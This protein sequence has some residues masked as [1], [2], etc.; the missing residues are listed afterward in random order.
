EVTGRIGFSGLVSTGDTTT[1]FVG[2][3]VEPEADTELS[4]MSYTVGGKDLV[5]RD[6][7]GVTLGLGLARAFGVSP[8]DDLT[9]LTTT[10]GGSINALAVKVRGIW[11]TGEKAYD[12]RFLKVGLPNVQRVLDLEH[13]E[14]QS[15]VVLLDQTENTSFVRDQIAQLIG[16]R[17]LALEMKT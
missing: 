1:S 13:G 7:R 16:E 17:K 5:S 12:D 11:E 14:V 15:V 3:G 6:P 2:T 8:G 4:S 10:K 9:L